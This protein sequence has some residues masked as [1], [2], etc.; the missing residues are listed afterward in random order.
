MCAT[1]AAVTGAKIVLDR[2][3][4]RV[5]EVSAATRRGPHHRVSAANAGG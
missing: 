4:S 5:S 3:A 2:P 1:S